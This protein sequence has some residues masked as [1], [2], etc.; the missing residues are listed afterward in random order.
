MSDS[1]LEPTNVTPSKKSPTIS[2][3]LF[4]N[5]TWTGAIQTSSL[6]LV[7]EACEAAYQ[8]EVATSLLFEISGALLLRDLT[9][10]TVSRLI[11][12]YCWGSHALAVLAV[13]AVL[14]YIRVVGF[15]L[16]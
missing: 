11:L 7:I 16:Q 9:A 6:G 2:W 10:R 8:M 13:L 3:S 5:P 15:L 1:E 14:C 4:R 12:L